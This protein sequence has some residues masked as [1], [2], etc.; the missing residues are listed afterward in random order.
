MAKVIDALFLRLR[1]GA[2]FYRFTWFNRI[3]LSAAFIP[4]GSVKLLGRRFTSMGPDTP[5]GAFFEAMFQ[6][7][8]FWH[9]IGLSQIVAGVLLLI[10]RFSHLGAAVFFPIIL[11][12][13]IITIGLD[14]G[15]TPVVTVSMLL[16]ISYLCFWDWHRFRPLFTTR[17]PLDAV[18]QPLLDKWE[19]AGFLTFGVCLMGFFLV[20]RGLL[21]SGTTVFVLALG[22]AAGLFTLGRYLW[23]WRTGRLSATAGVA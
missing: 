17:P 15:G 6:T 22:F 12:I 19:R 8:L 21:H 9:F 4:T 20:T 2:F 3:L 10:P 7:G 11:N 5:I 14:F 1:S 23:L 18:P 13:V 16:S